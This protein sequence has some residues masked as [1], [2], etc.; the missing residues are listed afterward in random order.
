MSDTTRPCLSASLRRSLCDRR[1]VVGFR[2]MFEA[3]VAHREDHR[4]ERATVVR[5]R[6]LHPNGFFA[7]DLAV[8]ELLLFEVVKAARKHFARNAVD[9]VFEFVEPTGAVFEQSVDDHRVPFLADE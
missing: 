8:D 4:F 3:P 9:V 5:E 7:D 1:L 6:V 2:E